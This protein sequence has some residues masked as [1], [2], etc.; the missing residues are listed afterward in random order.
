[1]IEIVSTFLLCI[2]IFWIILVLLMLPVYF[3]RKK[4]NPLDK[5]NTIK[6]LL[7]KSIIASILFWVIFCSG[8]IKMYI[9]DLN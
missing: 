5:N 3:I 7:I 6:R 4:R 9:D 2:I 8:L 1:M